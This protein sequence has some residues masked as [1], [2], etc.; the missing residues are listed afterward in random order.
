MK[1]YFWLRVLACLR[2]IARAEESRA[3]S[4]KEIT[5]LLAKLVLRGE[6]RRPGKLAELYVSTPDDFNAGYQR[7]REE[8]L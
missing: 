2:R 5:A 3:R 4:E 6:P 8:S 1:S 7:Q